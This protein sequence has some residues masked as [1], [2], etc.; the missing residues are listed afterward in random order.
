MPTGAAAAQAAQ[1]GS[2]KKDNAEVDKGPGS[3]SGNLTADP[4]LRFTASGRA[5]SNLR[6]AY[7]ERVRNPQTQEWEDSDP[8]FYDVTCWGQLA[9]NTA[10]HLQRGDRVVAEGRWTET[11]WTD[12]D[13]V[14]RTKIVLTARDLGPSMLFRGARV[15]RP[16]RSG[17]HGGQDAAAGGQDSG[18]AANGGGQ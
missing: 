4:D 2:R 6:V 7:S 9:E 13:G 14:V 16:D 5:V 18:Q 1:Q 3:V 17:G 15:Q 11:E 12:K 10:E 8:A